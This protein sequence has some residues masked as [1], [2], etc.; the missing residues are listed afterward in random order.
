MLAGLGSKVISPVFE[1]MSETFPALS[2]YKVDVDVQEV[3]L[4]FLLPPPPFTC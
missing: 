2:F 1:K 3:R 4:P